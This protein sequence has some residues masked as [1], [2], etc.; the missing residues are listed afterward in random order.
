V[1]QRQNV[2]LSRTEEA[3]RRLGAAID[4]LEGASARVGAGDLLL[5]GELRGAREDYVQL[6]ETARVVSQ[7]LDGVI[8]RLRDLLEE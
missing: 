4:R 1:E 7:R 8:D 6:E 5:A 3:M 2:S